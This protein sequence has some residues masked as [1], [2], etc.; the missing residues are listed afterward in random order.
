[1]ES[2]PTYNAVFQALV[3]IKNALDEKLNLLDERI[4]RAQ[5]ECVEHAFEQH[6]SAFAECLDGI[7]QQLIGLSV[8]VDEYRRL[9]A[10]LHDLN[11]KISEFGGVPRAMPERVSDDDMPAILTARIGH[12][13]SQGKI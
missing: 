2:E 13:K 6:Q 7:D 10:S 8:Y 9:Y 5:L 11:E 12:L 4:R 3:D 1:M